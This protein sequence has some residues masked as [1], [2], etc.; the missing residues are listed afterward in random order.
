MSEISDRYRRLSAGFTDRVAAVPDNRWA[1]PSPCEG[2]SARDLVGHV[3]GTQA[4]FLGLVDRPMPDGPSVED[5]P[6]TAWAHASSVVQADLDDPE[7]AT[8]AFTS[9][10]GETTFEAAIDRFLNFDL[11]VHGWDLARATGG[12]ERVDPADAERV[13]AGVAA[14]GDSIRSPQACGPEVAVAPDADLTTRMLA[15]VGRQA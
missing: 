11:V 6:A 3:V 7:R 15:L 9:F 8:F 12:D 1:S 2:W 4:M 14:F 13:I 5:D 10:F